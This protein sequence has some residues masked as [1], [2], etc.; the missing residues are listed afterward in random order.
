MQSRAIP[1][2]KQANLTPDYEARLLLNPEVVL[3]TE[4]EPTKDVLS[5]FGITTERTLMNVG[6]FD[7]EVKDISTAD[8]SVRIRKPEDKTKFELTYKK[9]YNIMRDNVD[10]VL[11]TAKDHGFDAGNTNNEAQVE[12]GF[13]T[14]TLSVSREKKSGSLTNGVDLPDEMEARKMLIDEAPD[15]FANWK[16]NKWGSATLNKS[17]F[18]GPVLAKRWIGSWSTIPQ[19][20]IEIWPIRTGSNGKMTYIVEASFKTDS[21]LTAETKKAD[22]M[23]FLKDRGWFLAQ[24]A[25]K[26][27]LILV[28]Y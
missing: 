2:P 3:N 6:F 1:S 18:Y 11:T 10:A 9:R 8:W 7:T 17:R 28:N 16:P 21:R 13:L 20:Y 5:A 19:L 25:L 14:R 27:Q 4:H 12:W 26:T 15:K 22:L 24:D 23:G